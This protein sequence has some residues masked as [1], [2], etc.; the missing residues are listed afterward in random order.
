[1]EEVVAGEVQAVTEIN[2]ITHITSHQLSTLSCSPIIIS[3]SL[4]TSQPDIRKL[5]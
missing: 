2:I 1:M 5:N 3:H 4:I